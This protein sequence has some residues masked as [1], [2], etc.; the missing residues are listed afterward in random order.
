MRTSENNIYAIA[1]ILSIYANPYKYIIYANP[2]K[3]RIYAIA[4][5]SPP[6]VMFC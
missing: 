4:D 5:F 3:M 2:Y 6:E 1:Y